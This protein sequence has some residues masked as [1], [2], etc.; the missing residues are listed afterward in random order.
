MS[1]LT[2]EDIARLPEHY[3]YVR[4]H[5]DQPRM[6][7]IVAV[8]ALGGFAIGKMIFDAYSVPPETEEE[9]EARRNV[10]KFLGL[11]LLA[12]GVFYALDIDSKWWSAESASMEAE[13]WLEK[14]AN[15]F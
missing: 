5:I 8:G 13:K 1:D 4:D 2:P 15:F 7:A 10:P 9:A 3:R 11:A 6:Q 12:G 14:N